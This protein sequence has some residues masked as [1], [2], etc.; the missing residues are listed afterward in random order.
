M[1]LR[2]SEDAFSLPDTLAW[3][4]ISAILLACAV[5]QRTGFGTSYAFNA[6]VLHLEQTLKSLSLLAEQREEQLDLVVDRQTYS[7]IPHDFPSETVA[8]RRVS[9]G[10]SIRSSTTT[11]PSFSLKFYP[12]GATSPAT[13]SISNGRKRCSLVLSLRGRV[14]KQC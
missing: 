7:V 10:V 14:S 1:K 3:L 12:S 11:S 13:L 8:T 5:P 9:R 4:L 2:S 6:E